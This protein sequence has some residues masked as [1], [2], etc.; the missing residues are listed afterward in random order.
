LLAHV[1]L[2]DLADVAREWAADADRILPGEGDL[3][4]AEIVT[5]LKALGYT[6]PVSVETMNP[7][8]WQVPALQFA[9]IATT[10]LRCVLGLGDEGGKA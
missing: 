5:A 9:E 1:Q 6:G 10:A 3:P 2:S 7:Q 8:L 4:V